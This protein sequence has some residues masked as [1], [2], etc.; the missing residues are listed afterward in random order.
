M[1]AAP[2]PA[3]QPNQSPTPTAQLA[4]F[5]RENFLKNGCLEDS[6]VKRWPAPLMVTLDFP[7][8]C[9]SCLRSFRNRGES[10]TFSPPLSKPSTL[11]WQCVV[12]S[13]P[14]WRRLDVLEVRWRG[15]NENEDPQEA[16]DVT[17]KWRADFHSPSLSPCWCVLSIGWGR[18]RDTGTTTVGPGLGGMP[19][20]SGVTSV[21]SN[22]TVGGMT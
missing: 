22:M 14:P 7:S 17:G 2:W 6:K 10:L 12:G 4:R 20:T 16:R 8:G 19:A 1:P 18:A 13:V 11:S 15:R 9:F 21:D 5:C 3:G